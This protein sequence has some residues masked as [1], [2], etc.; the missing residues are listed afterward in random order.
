MTRMCSSMNRI[1]SDQME[2]P[3]H[4]LIVDDDRE[5]RELLAEM[6]TKFG[7]KVILAADGLEMFHQLDK[8]SIDLI[9]LDVMLPGDDGFALCRKLRAQSAIPIIMLTAI[10]E[11]TDR[12]VG[13][14]CGADDYLAKPFSVRELVARIKAILRRSGDNTPKVDTATQSSYPSIERIK[15]ADWILDMATRRLISPANMEISLSAGEFNLLAT[16][17][18]SPMRVLSRD[19]LLEVTRNRTGG[20]FDRSVDIQVSRIRQKIEKDVK[21]PEIIVTV[22][23]GG[24]MLNTKIEKITEHEVS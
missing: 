12:I 2:R 7:Y 20:P 10:G 3:T 4:L 21:N 13:L 24:Y 22:R 5:I 8:Q 19:Q 6:L 15:F 14:E 18:K 9:V 16:F 17:L 1:G 11:E 23:G